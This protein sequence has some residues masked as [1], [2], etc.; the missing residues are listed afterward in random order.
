VQEQ[1]RSVQI[2]ES[3][4]GASA[5]AAHINGEGAEAAHLSTVPGD[6]DGPA[7]V[8]PLATIADERPGHLTWGA[9]QAGV[10]G[11]VAT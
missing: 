9:A 8:T 10:A 6:R 3:F 4:A 1:G 2:G 5:E 11:G 7:R